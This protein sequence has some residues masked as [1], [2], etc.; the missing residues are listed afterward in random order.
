MNALVSV[1]AVKEFFKEKSF[2][3]MLRSIEAKQLLINKKKNDSKRAFCIVHW[4]APRFLLLNVKRLQRLHPES[5]IYVF[6][7]ASSEANLKAVLSGL[8]GYENVTLFSSK[9]DYSQTGF[10]HLMGLQFLLNYAARRSDSIVVFLDQDCILASRIDDLIQR[11]DGEETLLV[12]VRDYVEIPKDYGLLKCT[13]KTLRNFPDCIHASFMIMQPVVI[14]ELFGDK[15]LF[16]GKTFEPYHGIARK[17]AGKILFLE[18]Q[19]HDE[20]PLL[21]SYTY[22]GRTYAWHAWYSSRIVRLQDTDVLDD[23]PVSWFR[24]ALQQSYEFMT[25]LRPK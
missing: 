17:A 4:N 13:R 24:S 11:L 23:L 8:Q 20:I 21:T 19:M 12:G 18:T 1:S 16:S 25:Q 6:D 15:S 5:K 22:Q 14:R 7:N 2:G 3:I 9:R 10:G